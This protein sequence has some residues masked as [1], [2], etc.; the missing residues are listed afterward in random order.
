MKSKSLEETIDDSESKGFIR[1]L[2][3]TGFNASIAGIATFLSLATVGSAGIIIGG[4]L[5]VGGAIG[6]F[7][8]NNPFY[9]ILNDSLK[10]YATI[11]TIIYPIFSLGNAT[12]GLIE[13]KTIIGK[14][15]RAIYAS[16]VFNAAFVAS[17]NA[18]HYL[19]DNKLNPIGITKAVSD[20]FYNKFKRTGGLFLP[21]YSLI[22]NGITQLPVSI[23]G[24]GGMP[25]FAPNALVAGIINEVYPIKKY[26][27]RPT[28]SPKH[29]LAYA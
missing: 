15:L 20:N 7:V 12:F 16:T 19:I 8:R 1:K 26:S 29:S 4:S 9:K 25:T 6:G 21:A 24:M 22:S 11:N 5:A 17:F 14:A 23:F 27:N 10:R 13:N 2:F 28:Y 3:N 18:V